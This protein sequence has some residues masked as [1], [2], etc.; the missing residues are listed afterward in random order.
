MPWTVYRIHVKPRPLRDPERFPPDTVLR[1]VD[2][3]TRQQLPPEGDVVRIT[4]RE[5]ERYWDRNERAGDVEVTAAA[6]PEPWADPPAKPRTAKRKARAS[7]SKS[8][9]EPEPEAS[10]ATEK[11]DD[12]VTS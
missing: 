2:P 4:S 9:P 6:E 1:V 11:E 7:K 3:N 5:I 8:G 12:E 10:A